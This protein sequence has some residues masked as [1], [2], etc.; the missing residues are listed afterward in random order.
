[1]VLEG[2][3][4]AGDVE[5]LSDS[6]ARCHPIRFD[7]RRYFG[8]GLRNGGECDH[9]VVRGI[10]DRR[11]CR[12]EYRL[13]EHEFVVGVAH[14]PLRVRLCDLRE[15]Q[16]Q[17]VSRIVEKC[18]DLGVDDPPAAV[19]R[20]LHGTD[21]QVLGCLRRHAI[22]QL[23]AFVDDHHFVIWE[24][25]HTVKC[26]DHEH[27]VIRHHDVDVGSCGPRLLGKALIAIRTLRRTDAFG[28][29]QCDATP[30]P[31][32]GC[33]FEV[34]AITGL[35][36]ERPGA[37]ALRFLAQRGRGRSE[38]RCRIVLGWLEIRIQP[39]LAHIVVTALCHRKRR[40][41]A[42]HWCEC[43]SNARQIAAHELAL[44]GQRR[45]GHHDRAIRRDGPQNR[46]DEIRHRLT[47][48]GSG[49]DEQVLTGVHRLLDGMCHRALSVAAFATEAGHDGVE[50]RVE[51]CH[52]AYSARSAASSSSTFAWTYV[53]S[54][55]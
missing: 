39:R 24:K 43:G 46:R 18:H 45:S 48:A 53:P 22:G 11:E 50:G 32:I 49:L 20:G 42:E 37:N 41:P 3:K 35:G 15:Q 40:F 9:R 5:H 54:S 30:H 14:N 28:T 31:R 27:R 55:R 13:P 51:R 12:N 4:T 29:A 23:V 7:I 52:C 17:T 26:V 38:Q 44:Q 33:R 10:T 16:R 6:S 19:R 21:G 2:E 8:I 25:W 34:F 1:M 36:E 47:R